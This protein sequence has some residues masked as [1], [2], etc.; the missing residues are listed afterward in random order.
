MRSSYDSMMTE[1][2][3]FMTTADSGPV[4]PVRRYVVRGDQPRSY[5]SRVTFTIFTTDSITG[6]SINTPT[7]VASAAPD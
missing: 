1:Y 6:T 5:Q 4:H 2:D 3:N 7:T